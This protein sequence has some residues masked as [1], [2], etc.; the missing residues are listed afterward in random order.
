MLKNWLQ[1]AGRK[2]AIGGLNGFGRSVLAFGLLTHTLI[3]PHSIAPNLI[4]HSAEDPTF[5]RPRTTCPAQLADL[6]SLLLRDLPSYANRV[7]QRAYIEAFRVSD[8]IPGTI[9][10]AGRPEYQPIEL[11]DREYQAAQEDGTS[12]VFFTTL[13]RQY[14]ADKVVDLQ[15]YYWLFLTQTEAGWQL[16]LLY[17]SLGD[18]PPDQPPTPPQ[19]ASQGVV[20]RAIRLWLRDCQAG[21]VLMPSSQQ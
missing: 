11:S 8:D 5:I 3:A 15:H 13:E 16:V 17:S 7:S 9:I 1:Q 10:L 18:N 21:S 12:Q 19:D 14:A 20:A 2:L 4:A 6:V